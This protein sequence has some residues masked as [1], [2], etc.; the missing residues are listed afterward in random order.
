VGVFVP[1]EREA[2]IH[3]TQGV[4]MGHAYFDDVPRSTKLGDGR[5]RG[6]VK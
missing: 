2:V 3:G 4:V 6:H 1:H 5:M